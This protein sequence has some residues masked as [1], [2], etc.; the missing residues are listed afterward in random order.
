MAENQPDTS[1]AAGVFYGRLKTARH[2][3]GGHPESFRPAPSIMIQANTTPRHVPIVS[4]QEI[5][6]TKKC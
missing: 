5:I 6:T 3:S 2:L 1:P 4:Y